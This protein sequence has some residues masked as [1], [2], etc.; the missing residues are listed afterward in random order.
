MISSNMR[1]QRRPSPDVNITPLI[2]VVFL[3]LIFFMVSTTFDRQAELKIELPRADAE[4]T[5]EEQASIDLTID[6]QGR[7]FVDRREV[8][9][10]SVDTLRR[11]LTKAVIGKGMDQESGE[12]PV[13]IS[14]DARTPHQSVIAAMDAAGR[15]GLYHIS[16]ATARGADG[17]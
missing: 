15:A 6:R 14:A 11:A 4:P 9:N 17:E 13:V 2:D 7:F 16:F 10:T 12:L 1:P 3:L 8:V 5:A